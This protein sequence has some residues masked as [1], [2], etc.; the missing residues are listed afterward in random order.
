MSS[1]GQDWNSPAGIRLRVSML[2]DYI[3][4]RTVNHAVQVYAA[5]AGIDSLEWSSAEDE[6][7]CEYCDSQQ[8]RRYKIGMFM[9][10]IPVH[11]GCRCQWDV[12]PEEY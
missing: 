1:D 4:V 2:A 5:E 3:E 8:G 7:V 11:V 10:D 6:G 9:P 12:I